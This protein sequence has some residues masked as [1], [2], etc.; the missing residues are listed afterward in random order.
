VLGQPAPDTTA[1]AWVAV[2]LQDDTARARWPLRIAVLDARRPTVAIVNDD[3]AGTGTTDRTLAGRAAPHGT[4]NWFFPNGTRAVVNGRWNDQVRLRLSERSVAWVDDVD[5]Q[6]LPEGT[7]PPRGTML[8]LRLFPGERSVALRIPLPG[9][10]PFRV[11][12]DDHRLTLTLYG[13]APDADWIQYG[14]TDS[15]VTLIRFA[16]PAQDE[17]EVVV[18]LAR[19]VW[20]YRTRWSGDDLLLEIR[21]PPVIDRRH[22][23]KGRV[24][25]LDAGHPPLGATGP[26]GA[27]EADVVL[28]VA[29]RA[30]AL[31]EGA[32]ARVVQI[33]P[34][35]TP[36]ELVERTAAAEAA[37]AD[38]LVSIHANALPDGVN[39]FANNG[40]STY[41]FQPRSA[42]FA[43]AMQRALVHELGVR[44]LGMGR[45]DLAL[46]RPT[47]MPAV[48]TEGLFM[49][50]PEQEEMLT[51]G[52]GQERYARG[53]VAGAAA[54]LAE[55]S[56]RP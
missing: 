36:L 9:R 17:T 46:A 1:L 47:W 48:L 28:A 10:V 55:W 20:G 2:V 54:F 24:I 32:G 23:L 37:D 16:A 51:S 6:A 43:R 22:P 31:L 34:D 19:P 38:L 7:P 15:L 18:D 39:P 50:I 44:D 13:V 21:R 33:R 30:Q 5:V 35:R 29:Q 12:E 49:M 4:Y 41:Y 42:A 56:R 40:T 26:T 11:D 25:A 27:Y 14:G 52:A 8:P 53:I 3:T 45:G